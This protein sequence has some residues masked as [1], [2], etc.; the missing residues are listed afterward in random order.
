MVETIR[1]E[2][3]ISLTYLDIINGDI[4]TRSLYMTTLLSHVETFMLQ[5]KVNTLLPATIRFRTKLHNAVYYILE[6]NHPLPVVMPEREEDI[7]KYQMY[8]DKFVFKIDTEHATEEDIEQVQILEDIEAISY[9]M[10]VCM[11]ATADYSDSLS[12]RPEGLTNA[13]NKYALVIRIITPILYRNKI[14][15]ITENEMVNAAAAGMRKIESARVKEQQ[16]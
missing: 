7:R 6:N 3:L 13:S 4:H 11:S 12:G 10:N 2:K 15:D 9:C 5:N 8:F 14:I 16:K 1:I